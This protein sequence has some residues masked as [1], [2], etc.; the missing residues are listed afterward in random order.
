MEK[1]MTL[2]PLGRSEGDSGGGRPAP[3]GTGW[4]RWIPLVVVSTS[5]IT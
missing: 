1:S 4:E 3:H 2:E 5:H